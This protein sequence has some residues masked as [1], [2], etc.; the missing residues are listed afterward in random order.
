[1]VLR[2]RFVGGRMNLFFQHPGVDAL[3][4]CWVVVCGSKCCVVAALWY[5][6]AALDAAL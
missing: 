3:L 1:M 4:R 2:C 6:Y 5:F